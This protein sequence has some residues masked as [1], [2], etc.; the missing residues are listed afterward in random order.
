[1]PK[2]NIEKLLVQKRELIDRLIEKY[3]PRKFTKEYLNFLVGRDSG[4]NIA[5]LQKTISDPL[6]N[7]LDRGGK[8]WRPILFLLI[9]EAFGGNL[10]KAKDFLIIPELIHEGTL[11]VDDIEDSS[12]LRRGERCLH[13]LFGQDVALNVGN[14]AYFLPLKALFA[15]RNSFPAELF[16]KA[17]GIYIQEM[18][19]VSVGQA[20]DI[21]WHRDLALP[22]AEEEYFEMCRQKSGAMVRLS[23]KLAA[24]FAGLPDI[25]INKLSRVADK[26]SVAFQIQDDVLDIELE[27][28]NRSRFGKSFGNDIK[29]G[30]KTLMVIYVLQKAG[31]ADKKKLLRVLKKH[32]SNFNEAKEA[33]DILAKYGAVDYARKKAKVLM[34]QAQKEIS[35]L[36]QGRRNKKKI[37]CLMDFLVKRS[38]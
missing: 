31:Q 10:K 8:R 15:K 36:L 12:E 5:L 35:V 32:T 24:V 37:Q 7:F 27:G 25:I 21:G 23:V 16:Q 20:V 19:N 4:Y 34:E 28:K 1:M 30:K 33:I 3:A 29:E 14:F 9:L 2:P 26:I 11:I 38:Y 18:I 13:H 22:G 6:W 17:Y